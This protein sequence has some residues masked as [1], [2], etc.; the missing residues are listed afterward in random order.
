MKQTVGASL[1][2]GLLPT[3]KPT[4]KIEIDGKQIDI[5][6]CDVANIIIYVEAK[7]VGM[8][9]TEPA[10]KITENK[11]LIARLK[12]IRGKGSMIL[13]KCS[14]WE[15]VDEEAPFLPMVAVV[16]PG[17]SKDEDIKVRLILDNRCHDSLAGTGAICLTACSQTNGTVVN[18]LLAEGITK[19][20]TLNILHPLG[21]MP[22]AVSVHEESSGQIIPKFETLS[23]IRTARRIM[24]GELH[25]PSEVQFSPVSAVS[26]EDIGAKPAEPENITEQLCRFISEIK[27]ENLPTNLI[28]KLKDLIL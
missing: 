10:D 6:I 25:V 15:K 11:A 3:N 22:V 5:S 28:A 23:F 14:Q 17:T 18:R 4:D 12:E 24:T 26:K 9:C 19:N 13:G 16:A 21:I 2:K 8:D 1:G 7:D 20:K 27:Y